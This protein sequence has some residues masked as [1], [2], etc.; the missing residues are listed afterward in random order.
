MLRVAKVAV[1][2]VG[3]A[4]SGGGTATAGVAAPAKL[5]AVRLDYKYTQVPA[6]TDVII[7]NM[8]RDI[9]TVSDNASDG[10]HYPRERA[11]TPTGGTAAA[12]DNIWEV[13]VVHDYVT[14]E[15]KQGNVADPALEATLFF[16]Y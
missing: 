15:V 10:V 8:G 11:N 3:G 16:D 4:G 9:Y 12:G 5:I 14:V 1:A 7:S 13:P 2:T 6:T